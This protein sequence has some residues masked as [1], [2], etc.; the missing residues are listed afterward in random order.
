MRGGQQVGVGRWAAR[1]CP[2][3]GGWDSPSLCPADAGDLDPF[4]CPS[5]ALVASGPVLPPLPFPTGRGAVA[6]AFSLPAPALRLGAL[7]PLAPPRLS[8]ILPVSAPSLINV[9]H[10]MATRAAF[11]GAPAP[12]HPIVPR[13]RWQGN[14]PAAHKRDET[15]MKR[16]EGAKRRGIFP[17]NTRINARQ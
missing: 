16:I 14:S 7:G 12:P 5:L 8:Q 10:D 4:P 11:F 15:K 9:K 13:L 1:P 3:L 17:R 2:Q 6:V